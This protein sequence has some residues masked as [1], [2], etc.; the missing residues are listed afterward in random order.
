ML[1]LSPLM[2]PL[3]WMSLDAFWRF[4]FVAHVLVACGRDLPAGGAAAPGLVGAAAAL[5]LVVFN[6]WLIQHVAIGYTRG[7]GGLRAADRRAARRPA[8]SVRE[9]ALAAAL[10]ALIV[11]EGGFHVF[12]WL[13]LTIV[14]VTAI[15]W[16][17]SRDAGRRSGWPAVFAGTVLLALP[18]LV[19]SAIAF[20]GCAWTC[21]AATRAPPTCGGC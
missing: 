5:V 12:V 15:A 19:A 3:R 16:L 14:L 8:V 9:A 10:D 21:S 7:R 18:K 11:Y 17:G 2:V 4:Y 20:A 6:P 1:T 13:N